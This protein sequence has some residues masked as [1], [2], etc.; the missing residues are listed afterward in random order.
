[1]ND[2]FHEIDSLDKTH[3]RLTL[4]AYLKDATTEQL[5]ND[6]EQ[7][8]SAAYK[9]AGLMATDFAQS[10]DPSDP[11]NE[12]FTIA[13]ELEINPPEATELHREL[14]DKINSL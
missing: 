2:I 9:I 10:L 3:A 8:V 14:I 5:G 4:V 13:G 1:M 11:I 7:R 12:I 6:P